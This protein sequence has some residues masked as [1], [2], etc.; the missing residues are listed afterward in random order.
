MKILHVISSIDPANGGP[1]VVATRLAA[2]QASIGHEVHLLTYTAP[3][4][5]EA[6]ENSLDGL[7]GRE[8]IRFHMIE[9]LT[10]SESFTGSNAKKMLDELCPQMDFVHGHNVWD[11]T[12]RKMSQSCSKHQVPYTIC[13]HGMLDPWCMTQSRVKKRIAL[14]LGYRAALV[15]CRF[16]HCLNKDEVGFVKVHNFGTALEIIPNGIFIEEFEPPPEK[17]VFRANHPE[18]GD[19]PYIFFLSRLH[20]KK[21]L[22]FLADAFAAIAK[23]FPVAM[24]VVAGPDGGAQA[25]F[26][27]RIASADLSDRVLITG[28]IYGEGKLEALIDSTC[29]CLPSR[30]EGFSIAITESLALG[31]PVVVTKACHYP[32]VTEVNAGIETELCV[33]SIANGLRK[34]LEA[35]QDEL[36][37]QGSNGMSLIRE[38]FTW[39]IVARQTIE[40]YKKYSTK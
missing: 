1:P 31:V 18:I 21:G 36:A 40:L 26:E 2:A 30:Q 9:P 14:K 35:T 19:K 13:L 24:L 5:E 33:E 12:I 29:F 34:T 7:P 10:R 8:L 15:G 20:Y 37:I 22:D 39:P 32:E 23:E 17:G 16:I 38:R 25:D 6:I 4:R 11:T 27:Q 3:G 28:P